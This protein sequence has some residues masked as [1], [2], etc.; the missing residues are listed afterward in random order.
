MPVLETSKAIKQV[1]TGETIAVWT[2]D[3]AA[4]SDFQAWSKRTGHELVGVFDREGYT[5]FVIKRT[6]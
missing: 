3:P 2:T 1:N 6:K 4:K 5:E